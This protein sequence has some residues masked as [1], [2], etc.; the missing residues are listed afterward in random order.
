MSALLAKDLRLSADVL[1]P[2][3]LTVVGFLLGALVVL[4]LPDTVL[5]EALVRFTTADLLAFVALA[6]GASGLVLSAWAAAAIVQGD[7]GH[8]AE[9]LAASLPLSGWRRALSKGVVLVAALAV[10][11]AVA[12][13]AYVASGWLQSMPGT[14]RPLW[15]AQFALLASLAGAGFAVPFALLLRGAWKV[16]V[17][18]IVSAIVAAGLSIL[19]A[20]LVTGW[21]TSL[22][23][24]ARNA[25]IDQYI[26]A[27]R[28]D[29]IH[30]IGL[31]FGLAGAAT[32]GLLGGLIG[33]ARPPGR[34]LAGLTLAAAPVA[35]FLLSTFAARV[36]IA[37]DQVFW[38]SSF[39]EVLLAHEA[40]DAVIAQA[41]LDW[42]AA[43][44]ATPRTRGGSWAEVQEGRRRVAE[45]P[46][47]ERGGSPIMQAILS[48]QDYSTPQWAVSSLS[49]LPR[50][51]RRL[52]AAALENMLRYPDEPYFRSVLSY[53]IAG[54][55]D[56]VGYW[57]P[58]R[59]I[60]PRT[61]P[62][63]WRE[64]QRAFDGQLVK[65]LEW[66]RDRGELDPAEI[67]R[68]IELLRTE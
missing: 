44:R 53:E 29:R 16:V 37:R 65:Q 5:P 64:A 7:R 22:V 52:R 12:T 11:V 34:R 19:G 55:T 41:I 63:A 18:A 13:I 45:M 59:R 14:L 28:A 17:L 62:E 42:G 67:D 6:T 2:W 8:G 66:L 27:F 68:A 21:F 9:L 3:I 56:S 60:D 36:A 35:A 48:V 24:T 58:D 32:I 23:N 20:S 43:A 40:P 33:V 4:R 15:T 30:A 50:R 25:A 46:E 1:R 31:S 39:G 57:M 26:P 38:S 47:A 49:M 61:E 51:D 54:L 10:P